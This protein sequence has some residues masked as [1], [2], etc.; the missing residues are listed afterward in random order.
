MADEEKEK[1]PF[2]KARDDS[3]ESEDDVVEFEYNADPEGSRQGG[4]DEAGGE[5]E[6]VKKVQKLKLELKACR[7]EKEEYLTGWQ[8]E[9]ADF[10]NYKKEED[11]RRTVFSEAMRERILS[12]FLSVVDSFSLA[13]GN[14]AAWAKVDPNWRVGIEHIYSDL[15]K[16]FEEYGVKPVGEAGELFDPNIHQSIDVVSTGDKE[17]D[18]TVAEVIQQGYRLGERILRPARVNVY[19]FR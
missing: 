16:I 3:G 13:M 9:R 14:K 2:D 10:V 4:T 8:K 15:T 19:E 12:R 18:H 6:L 7:K 5:E 11:G 1:E 17:K